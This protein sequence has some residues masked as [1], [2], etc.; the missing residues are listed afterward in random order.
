[1][2][3]AVFFRDDH[4][5]PLPVV[6]FSAAHYDGRRSRTPITCDAWP[7]IVKASDVRRWRWPVAIHILSFN[8]FSAWYAKHPLEVIVR[9][10]MSWDLMLNCWQSLLMRYLNGNDC[11]QFQESTEDICVQKDGLPGLKDWSA[12]PCVHSKNYIHGVTTRGDP[13]GELRQ[14]KK[15]TCRPTELP[16]FRNC[17]A[18]PYWFPTKLNSTFCGRQIWRVL[19]THGKVHIMW[20]TTAQHG[21]AWTHYL[22]R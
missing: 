5:P 15:T 13:S 2:I 8:M 9:Q 6:C 1:M 18:G 14:A 10:I 20:K 4:H 12:Q 22:Y 7:F 16:R 21:L 17:H 11:Q 19:C 3:Y